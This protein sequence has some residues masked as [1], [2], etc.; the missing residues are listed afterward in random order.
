[1]N[2][3]QT[4]WQ[5]ELDK[6]KNGFLML[7]GETTVGQALALLFD[8]ET[9]GHLWWHLIIPDSPG[10]RICRFQQIAPENGSETAWDTSLADLQILATADVVDLNQIG[11]GAANARANDVFGKVLVVIDNDELIGVLSVGS[12]RGSSELA[13]VSGLYALP[14]KFAELSEFRTL[15]IKKRHPQK[16]PK[17][18]KKHDNVKAN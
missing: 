16:I 5:E 4:I 1:M 12:R 10:W 6:E 17:R 14:G 7:S 13:A 15:L 8:D 3:W 18:S 2:Y 11:V 9:N